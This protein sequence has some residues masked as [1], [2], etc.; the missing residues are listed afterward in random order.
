MFR[1]TNRSSSGAQNCNCSLWFYIR[2]WLLAT[3]MA[4][5]E[6]RFTYVCGCWQLSWLSGNCSSHSASFSI[7]FRKNRQIQN[8]IEIRPVE[9]ELFHADTRTD[10]IKL[11]L[12]FAILRTRQKRRFEYTPTNVSQTYGPKK[13]IKEA[14]FLTYSNRGFHNDYQDGGVLQ[15]LSVALRKSHI[16]FHWVKITFFHI[17]YITMF[18]HLFSSLSYDRSKASSKASSPHSASQS[19]LPQMRVPSP[20]LKVIQQLPTSSSLSSCHFYPS[21]YLSFNNPL[22]KAVST[23][24]VTN[25]VCLPFTY[26]MQDI[27]LQL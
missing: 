18:I 20:F 10:I 11:V 9:A 27:P 4:E 16:P 1:A 3:V 22:Q 8:F 2:L 26:F 19:F 14:I 17:L 15:F 5:W 12:P 25:P 24:N 7:N 13:L 6:L 23:Q 21:L